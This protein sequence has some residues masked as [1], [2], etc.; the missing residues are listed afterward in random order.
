MDQT[1]RLPLVGRKLGGSGL[2]VSPE[3]AR[4]SGRSLTVSFRCSPPTAKAMGPA[5][6]FQRSPYNLR[7]SSISQVV[8]WLWVVTKI[9]LITAGEFWL[10]PNG[11]N[12]VAGFV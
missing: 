2:A 3:A 4:A 9:L 12:A 5:G 8:P 6:R 7:S 10:R 1:S 11:L